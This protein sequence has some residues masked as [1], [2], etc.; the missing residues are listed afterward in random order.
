MPGLSKVPA[1]GHGFGRV[2]LKPGG[3][4]QALADLLS[5]EGKKF[6]GFV[7]R[8]FADARELE[9]EDLVQDVF[10]RLFEKTDPLAEVGNLSA[11][12]YRSL[13]NAVVDSLRRRKHMISL[14]TRFGEDQD[15]SLA[16][17]LADPGGTPLDHLEESQR[18]EA[19][20]RAYAQLSEPERAILE[21][22]GFEGR[23][24]RELSEEWEV[25][26]GT[27]LSR[28]NRAVRHMAELLANDLTNS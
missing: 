27:L 28:K 20:E 8:N 1:T 25:P 13:R 22:N 7:R 3:V 24:F 26:I 12:V 21:A 2:F 14:Y 23:S 5:A 10:A 9:A 17:L 15:L 18:E 16:D 11:Y 6:A 19:F 4:T